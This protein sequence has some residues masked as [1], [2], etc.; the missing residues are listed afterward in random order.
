MALDNTNFGSVTYNGIRLT[1]PTLQVELHI[2]A[3]PD[4]ASRTTAYTIF[5]L[6]I[7]MLLTNDVTTSGSDLV[8]GANS[9]AGHDP[10]PPGTKIPNAQRVGGGPAGGVQDHERVLRAGLQQQGAALHVDA[11][12]FMFDIGEGG[13]AISQ[14][15]DCLFGPK[16]GPMVLTP[17]GNY[18][19]HQLDWTIEW[20]AKECLT[21]VASSKGVQSAF[22]LTHTVRSSGYSLAYDMDEHGLTTRTVTGHIEIFL[23]RS[24]PGSNRIPTIADALRSSINVVVPDGFRRLRRA[25][26]ISEDK[27]RLEYVITDQELPGDNAFPP[28]V[29]HLTMKHRVTTAKGAF[30]TSIQLMQTLSG[31]ITVA[32][33]Y[34]VADGF[35]R[36]L[37]IV[38]S[39]IDQARA[40]ARVGG[41]AGFIVITNIDI[42][43]QLFGLKVV[44]YSVSFIQTS[45]KAKGNNWPPGNIVGRSGIFDDVVDDIGGADFRL[46]GGAWE[47]WRD[48]TPELFNDRGFAGLTP[49]AGSDRIIDACEALSHVVP[50]DGQILLDIED[51]RGSLVNTC[52]TKLDNVYPQYRSTLEVITDTSIIDTFTSATT[53]SSPGIQSS[54]V[55][56]DD[57]ATDDQE[58]FTRETSND[59]AT[60]WKTTLGTPEALII[61]RGCARRI[62]AKPELPNTAFQLLKDFFKTGNTVRQIVATPLPQI[63]RAARGP[64]IG[65]CKVF[66][67]CWESV[68]K[69]D[70][71][72]HDPQKFDEIINELEKRL[73]STLN[74][75]EATKTGGRT[76]N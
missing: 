4:D 29:S 63:T 53:G 34:S 66:D 15:T 68:W 70:N 21:G 37:A 19:A 62:G 56:V 46:D 51:G 59:D 13:D 23:N 44:N 43:R 22:S 64:S 14:T 57:E 49:T 48:Q 16:P 11:F 54:R 26:R 55:E 9:T 3:I 28:G 17:V 47:E 5:R 20:H 36:V 50:Q 31:S 6:R 40:N 7:R 35:S 67:L 69:I 1:G 39:R 58:G 76:Q 2:T 41:I 73:E 52:P 60:V 10:G 61:F 45:G 32:K 12:G 24:N 8:F 25:Y 42:D 38:R 33:R 71:I 72:G 30:A 65:G 75:I 27:T 18:L 74:D